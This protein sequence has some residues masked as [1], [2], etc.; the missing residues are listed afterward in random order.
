MDIPKGWL[1]D[2]RTINFKRDRIAALLVERHGNTPRFHFYFS[3]A[4]T[5]LRVTIFSWRIRSGGFATFK[6]DGDPCNQ[7]LRCFIHRSTLYE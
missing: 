3:G 4:N 5:E 2:F 7:L 6:R 1:L